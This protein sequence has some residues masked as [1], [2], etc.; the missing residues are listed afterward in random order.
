MAI[1]FKQGGV[2]TEIG[3]QGVL[4]SWFSTVAVKLEGGDW[5]SRYPCVMKL[6]YQGHLSSAKAQAALAELQEI[7]TKLSAL[8]VQDP[9]WDI[10]DPKQTLPKDHQRNLHATSMAN[11]FLTV[12]GLDLTA[13]FIGNVESLLEFGGTLEIISVNLPPRK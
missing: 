13:E 7:H 6:L 5:G 1:A 8:S 10:E 12:N 4:H 3:P 2:I 9:V 11:Y